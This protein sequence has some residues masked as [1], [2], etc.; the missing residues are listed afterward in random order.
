MVIFTGTGRSGTKWLAACFDAYHE[1]CT[2][3]FIIEKWPGL[4]NS[5]ENYDERLEAMKWHLRYVDLK[6]FRDSSNI[7]I[8]FLDVLSVIDPDIRI[9]L[10]IRNEDDFI[11]SALNKG[12][13]TDRYTGYHCRPI[14]GW[15]NLNDTQKMQ[16]LYKFKLDIAKKRLNNVPSKNKFI[17]NLEK[18]SVDIKPVEK[19]L[20]ITANSKFIHEVV[21]RGKYA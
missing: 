18:I 7:Y 14:A 13:H 3:E 2:K 6:K 4:K 12:W 10:C 17:C 5:W 15:G 19:F 8:H 16:W 1:F 21:N 20:G 11:R 9:V